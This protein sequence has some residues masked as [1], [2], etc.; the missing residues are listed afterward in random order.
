MNFLNLLLS[1]FSGSDF[2]NPHDVLRVPEQVIAT[3]LTLKNDIK[4]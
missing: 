3:R 4:A 2:L 1:F